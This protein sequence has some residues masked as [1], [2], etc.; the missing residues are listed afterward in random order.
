[1]VNNAGQMTNIENVTI[2]N[3]TQIT[4]TSSTTINNL[5]DIHVQIEHSTHSPEGKK[6]IRETLDRFDDELKSKPLPQVIACIAKTVA[7]IAH[8]M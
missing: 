8:L 2:N 4:N 7:P 6:I 5:H 3:F 1:M